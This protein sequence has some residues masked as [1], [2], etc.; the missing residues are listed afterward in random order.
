MSRFL[1]LLILPA[2]LGAQDAA[3]IE[4]DASHKAAYVIP[5]TIYGTF[6]EPIGNSIYGGLWAQLLENP[7][8]ED[9]L[10]SAD[11][12]RRKLE[13]EPALARSSRM[14]LPLPWE[15]LKYAQGW[16]FEPRWGDAGNSY[17]SLLLMGLPDA[18]VGVRQQVYLP[19]HRAL[20]YTGS[21]F[22]KASSA[23]SIRVSLRKRNNAD[24]VLA[25]SNVALQAGAWRKYEF[26]LEL[27][28]GQLARLEAAD[29]VVSVPGEERLLIDQVLLFPAD[30]I[31]G[32]DP[33]MISMSKALEDT[34]NSLRRKFH[35]GLSLARWRRPNG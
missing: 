24:D 9:N 32:M 5:R 17:R 2:L 3:T 20:R 6:L 8:F 34:R 10:W 35:I 11:G 33:E 18:E 21:I 22:V 31:D 26:A 28:P 30:N 7:S 16:R 15:P 29:F 25:T 12:I 4:I 19:V 1:L 14:G 13:R 23:S 27:K